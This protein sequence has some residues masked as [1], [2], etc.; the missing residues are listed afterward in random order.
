MMLMEEIGPPD[1]H[2]LSAAEGWLGLGNVAEARAELSRI[3]PALRMHP[4]VLDVV[5]GLAAREENWPVALE[6]ARALLQTA[7]EFAGSW[8]HQA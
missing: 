5:W 6:A 7:P 8:L 2:F 1:S 3:D 4:V